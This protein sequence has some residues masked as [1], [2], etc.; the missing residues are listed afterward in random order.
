MSLVVVPVT[1][2]VSLDARL[3]YPHP[4]SRSLFLSALQVSL[5]HCVEQWIL[6]GRLWTWGSEVR[7]PA[8]TFCAAVLAVAHGS[9]YSYLWPSRTLSHP[10]TH[11]PRT[12]PQREVDPRWPRCSGWVVTYVL[13][14]AF[15]FFFHC[16]CLPPCLSNETLNRGL[17]RLNGI[18]GDESFK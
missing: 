6:T 1:V 13:I 18:C 16:L 3:L 9:H 2:L 12:R 17:D 8:A 5:D 4:A 14:W 10:P 7:S 11:P 15:F